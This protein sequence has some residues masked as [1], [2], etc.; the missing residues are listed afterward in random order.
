MTTVGYS[1]KKVLNSFVWELF[2]LYKNC[3]VA[4]ITAQQMQEPLMCASSRT[5]TTFT[6]FYSQ[7]PKIVTSTCAFFIFQSFFVV[8]NHRV[9][10]HC[11]ETA[12]RWSKQQNLCKHGNINTSSQMIRQVVNKQQLFRYNCE[13]CK[14]KLLTIPQGNQV[15]V[16]QQQMNKN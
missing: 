16:P 10:F 13:Y 15:Q 5:V 4:N 1:E 9:W 3:A 6:Y 11:G 8:Y 12:L 14:P 2:S 7:P